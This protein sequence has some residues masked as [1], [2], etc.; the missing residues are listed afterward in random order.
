[1]IKF[2]LIPIVKVLTALARKLPLL[3]IMSALEFVSV[4]SISFFC[5]LEFKEPKKTTLIEKIIVS[6]K[7]NIPAG[8]ETGVLLNLFFKETFFDDSI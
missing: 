8:E 1:M 2:G 3:S 7:L 6:G 5:N 4:C